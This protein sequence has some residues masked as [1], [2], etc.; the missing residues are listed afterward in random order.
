MTRS[1]FFLTFSKENFRFLPQPLPRTVTRSDF[2]LTF[3]KENFRF[4]PQPLPRTVTRSD[5][6]LTF[7]KN[8]QFCRFLPPTPPPHG[9]AP[10][11]ATFMFCDYF[12]LFSMFFELLERFF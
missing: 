12:Y 11:G 6:F 2:F 1:D 8:T 10:S 4:L 3:S 7:S 9:F 5:F